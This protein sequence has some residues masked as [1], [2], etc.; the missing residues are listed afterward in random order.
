MES[1][2][3]ADNEKSTRIESAITQFETRVV[4]LTDL[5]YG[6]ESRLLSKLTKGLVGLTRLIAVVCARGRCK[7]EDNEEVA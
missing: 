4:L 6:N 7:D 5:D 3:L 2:A 1:I